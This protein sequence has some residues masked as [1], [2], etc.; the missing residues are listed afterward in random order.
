MAEVAPGCWLCK[1]VLP[2][3]CRVISVLLL[4]AGFFG[5]RVRKRMSPCD[6]LNSSNKA[7][8]HHTRFEYPWCPYPLPTPGGSVRSTRL[9][10]AVSIAGTPAL[11]ANSGQRAIV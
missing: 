11:S 5:R 6:W 1:S 2:E 4:G 10:L 8:K 7:S 9:I 3:Y